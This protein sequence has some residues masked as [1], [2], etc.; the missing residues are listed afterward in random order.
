MVYAIINETSKVKLLKG[1]RYAVS[2]GFKQL[3]DIL[4][5]PPVTQFHDHRWV[6]YMAEIPNNGLVFT[7]TKEVSV[8]GLSF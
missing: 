7:K 2:H 8:V 3:G 6:Q 5:I 1:V 4:H